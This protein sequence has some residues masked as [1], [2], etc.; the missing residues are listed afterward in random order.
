MGLEVDAGSIRVPGYVRPGAIDV[1]MEDIGGHAVALRGDVVA[2]ADACEPKVVDVVVV[3]VHAHGSLVKH[4]AITGAW[5]AERKR[6][7]QVCKMELTRMQGLRVHSTNNGV[8]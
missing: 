8:V 1:I 6:R 4:N 5:G 7:Q 3:H 2:A